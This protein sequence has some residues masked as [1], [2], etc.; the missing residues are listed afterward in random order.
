MEMPEAQNKKTQQDIHEEMTFHFPES[1]ASVWIPSLSFTHTHSP[2][3]S[4]LAALIVMW[5]FLIRKCTKILQVTSSWLHL[6]IHR[7]FLDA[8]SALRSPN[9][10]YEVQQLTLPSAASALSDLSSVQDYNHKRV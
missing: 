9:A 7:K 8:T 2:A 3:I 4:L 10:K 6:I 5:I 1:F